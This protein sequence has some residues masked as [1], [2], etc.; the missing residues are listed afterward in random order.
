MKM[1][2]KQI[3]DTLL[4][5]EY[6]NDEERGY[7]IMKNY[8]VAVDENILIKD[9]ICTAGSKTLYN[10]KSPYSATVIEKI[11]AVGMSV[12][13][14]SK[15]G[16]FGG[17]VNSEPN[18]ANAAYAVKSGIAD[19]AVGIDVDGGAYRSA[20]KNGVVYIKPTYGT[21]SRF[22]V[23]ANVSSVDQIGVY[24]KNFDDGFAVLSEIAGYDKND[25]TLYP[26]EKYEY[27]A[28][29]INKIDLKSLKFAKLNNFFCKESQNK[30]DEM[31]KNIDADISISSVDYK[32]AEYLAQ[33]YFIISSAEFSNNITRFDG[34]K[35]GYR[36]ENF[37]NVN[38]IMVN[39]RSEG[40]TTETKIKSLMGYYV[41]SEKQFDKYYFKA[42]Q[43]RRLIKQ[44]LDEIFT[45]TDFVMLPVYLSDCCVGT[46]QAY[47]DELKF[48]ALANLTGC[49]AIIVPVSDNY[50]VQI[51][52]KEFNENKLFAI[53][54]ALLS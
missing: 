38:D 52:A 8:K 13:Y 46:P 25:G 53:G 4:C 9:E 30:I 45:D 21:V 23:V 31:L 41:L 49:P 29:K 3:T 42:M 6:L 26:P 51:I 44:E 14:K 54:K 12:S 27:S 47:H 48:S 40:F 17:E 11:K 2:L 18:M 37:K 15:T 1:H 5:R 24:S 7:E 39:S 28:D 43:I 35:F 20:V 50:G 10:F 19:V 33:V 22:G 36:T 34:I 32:F 16:E